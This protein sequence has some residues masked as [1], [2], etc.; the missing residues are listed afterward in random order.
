MVLIVVE[1]QLTSGWLLLFRTD[2]ID[3]WNTTLDVAV[4]IDVGLDDAWSIRDVPLRC[5]NLESVNAIAE[6]RIEKLLPFWKCEQLKQHRN[7]SLLT[8]SD[9][10]AAVCC[11]ANI[12]FVA[13]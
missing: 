7:S 8:I 1:D 5:C 4:G 12:I 13:L 3:E 6:N 10:D 2:T 11:A 9:V